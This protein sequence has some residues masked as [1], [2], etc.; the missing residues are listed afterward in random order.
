MCIKEE[1]FIDLRN[2]IER[3]FY[4][5]D[6]EFAAYLLEKGYR[7]YVSTEQGKA[8]IYDGYADIEHMTFGQLSRK[9]AP[10]REV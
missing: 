3:N 1:G 2:G 10:K 5:I 6:Y 7:V 4:R 8:I 9:R